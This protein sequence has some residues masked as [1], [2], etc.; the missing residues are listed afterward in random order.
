MFRLAQPQYLWLLL[1]IPLLLL[2]FA[3]SSGRSRALLK[4]FGNLQLLGLLMPDYSKYRGW[5]KLSIVCIAIALFSF[6]MT[7]PQT[8]A[9]AKE[10]N[11][12]GIEAII[13]L[14]VSNSMLA[15]D[16]TPNRLER[17]K[18]AVY[19]MVDRMRDNRIGLVVFAGGAYVQLPVTSDFA[20]AKI[21]L[22]SINTGMVPKQGTAIGAAI[23]AAV[24]SFS[25]EGA[26]SRV[27][28]V[29]SDGENHEDDAIAAAKQAS[30]L[31]IKVFTIGIGSPQGVPIPTS[32][33]M[34]KDKNGEVVI[35]K[36]DE[37]TLTE[38][39]KAGNGFYM[40]AT[41]TDIGLGKLMSEVEGMDKED[42]S[43]IVYQEYNELYMFF[44]AAAVLLL[45]LEPLLLDRKNKFL[46]SI[47]IFQVKNRS[48]SI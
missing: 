13:A 16:F 2:L 21:F 44:F 18:M 48:K 36:L 47:D 17:A 31:G 43:A 26:R 38:I 34:L 28:I 33:G 27:L 30:D 14:D 9:K 29:I 15:E 5:V 19:R 37:A 40:R 3:L 42:F 11:R 7:R 1:L 45:L 4:R 32:G 41:D 46:N 25:Q 10:V 22:S 12:R 6:G 39:A 8:G 20:S 24:Q 23:T 35:T